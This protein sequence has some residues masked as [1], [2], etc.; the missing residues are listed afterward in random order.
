MENLIKDELMHELQ[1]LAYFDTLVKEADKR[2]L[3]KPFFLALL[4]YWEERLYRSNIRM[5][6]LDFMNEKYHS[7]E[8]TYYSDQGKEDAYA[9]IE[10]LN[11]RV[12][13]MDL[14]YIHE[15]DIE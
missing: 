14:I 6:A 3:E 1:D 2:K 4:P 9:L 7:D 13:D 12:G 5:G 11:E 15:D 10:E 8:M